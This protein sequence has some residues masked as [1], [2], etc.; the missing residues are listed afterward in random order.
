MKVL[1]FGGTS[2]GCADRIR[3]VLDIVAEA[4]RGG[5]VAVV[6]SAMGGVTNG[7]VDACR[8]AH[9]GERSYEAVLAELEGRHLAAADALLGPRPESG[10]HKFIRQCFLEL[11]EFL[12]GI[13]IL[14]ELT[15]RTQDFVMSFGEQ[16]SCVLMAEA[17]N[18]QGV[19]A[20]YVDSRRL[21]RTDLSYG[22][23]IVDFNLTNWNILQHFREHQA[24]AVVTGF[25]A[26]GP[27]NETTTLGRGGSDYT[28]SILGAALDAEEIEIWTDVDGVMT[29]DPRQVP[30]AFSLERLTFEEAM[31]LSHFGAK[32]IHPPTMLPALRKRIPIRIRNTFRPGFPGTLISDRTED[33]ASL[34]AKGI[35][36][37]GSISLV[38]VAGTDTLGP[39]AIAA[40]VFSTLAER[41]IPVAL[42]T[43][44]SS[45]HSLCLAVGSAHARTARETLELA[46][47][48]E[49]HH[50]QITSV[51]VEDG[52]AIIA[53]VG[54]KLRESTRVTEQAFAALGRHGIAP[55][56]IA[57]G[58]SGR[59]LTIALRQ[60]ELERAMT[61][62]HAQLFER[63][64]R[65]FRVFLVG[66]G[67]V[68]GALL[69]LLAERSEAEGKGL[70]VQF[71]LAG[72][73]D[74]RRLLLAGSGEGIPW[75]LWRDALENCRR[76]ADLGELVKEACRQDP[77]CTVVVDCT[78]TTP[79]LSH[80]LPLLEAGVSV[81]TPSK[82]ANAG[83][84]EHYRSLREAAER[85]GA[86]FRYNTN[87]GA[88]LPV[89]ES[90]R[91][92]ARSGD[93]FRRIE[94]VVSGTL[95]YIFHCLHRGLPFAAAVRDAV[96]RGYAEPDPR[97]DLSG[98]DMA[99][100]LLIMAREAGIPLE[101]EDIRME[102]WLPPEVFSLED[103]DAALALAEESLAARLAAARSRENRLLVTASWS[104][105]GARVG[106]EE[107]P[108]DHPFAHLSGGDNMVLLTTE[109]L[110][111]QPLVIRG[112][113]AGAART[114]S[115]IFS[116]LVR[117]AR[118]AR[119][120][121]P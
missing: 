24:L 20:E 61:I 47:R 83:P 33:D 86:Q 12:H 72:V 92:I 5:P 3:E 54:E 19:G 11:D 95:A 10:A 121:E 22:A 41:K 49:I 53:V 115:G 114:A 103:L 8:R 57:L 55:L 26:C 107:I 51:A 100:K 99:R 68:G 84:L 73:A 98:T 97:T 70:G 28:A 119:R 32:V 89:L 6:S 44:S 80:Y 48:V 37:T 112:A 91:G 63:R 25:L 71:R 66:P 65:P 23:A 9:R 46:F 35:A 78:G 7:L 67:L 31:E 1:K 59:N 106:L 76:P 45:E 42:V 88:A 2:V 104:E 96:A 16:L 38:K 30:A 4:R 93:A 29:A 102:P 94:A 14:G 79:A 40:R 117:V 108:P 69:D 56:A 58:A 113:G 105:E 52:C 120:R 116:D 50:G 43:Q 15:A 81:V 64:E 74:R 111:P 39:A 75:A 36:A 27:D 17:L 18:R 87:V 85:S 110:Y 62:L 109:T 21:I 118:S 60:D 34:P 101:P 77:A 90:I 13:W 82:L